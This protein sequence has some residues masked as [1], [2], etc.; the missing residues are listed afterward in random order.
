ME[1][2]FRQVA[3]RADIAK[4]ATIHTLCHSF[5]TDLLEDDCNRPSI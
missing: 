3:Q 4:L 5:E 1:K 2:V